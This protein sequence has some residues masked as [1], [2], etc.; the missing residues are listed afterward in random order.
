MGTGPGW[1]LVRTGAFS[2]SLFKRTH[3]PA[4]TEVEGMLL[5]PAGLCCN[6]NGRILFVHAHVGGPALFY[7]KMKAN[8]KPT[9]VINS[10]TACLGV[11]SPQA[12]AERT[13]SPGPRPPQGNR[14]STP[15]K[16]GKPTRTPQRELG[17][18][19]R[20]QGI[21]AHKTSSP[22]LRGHQSQ[23]VADPELCR[24]G[25]P[26]GGCGCHTASDCASICSF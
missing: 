11:W 21:A 7:I 12:G 24:P 22:S 26:R 13:L 20:A 9:N 15:G 4:W 10:S 3:S 23:R 1:R 6:F 19:P 8:R 2:G 16:R 17:G 14:F 5:F 25:G 18:R